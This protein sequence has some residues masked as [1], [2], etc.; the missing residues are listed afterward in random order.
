MVI[1]SMTPGKLNDEIFLTI[2][3]IKTPA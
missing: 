1:T 2:L 3:S